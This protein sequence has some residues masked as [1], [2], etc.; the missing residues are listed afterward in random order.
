MVYDKMTVNSSVTMKIPD[1]EQ[2]YGTF[3]SLLVLF[4]IG[5]FTLTPFVSVDCWWHMRMAEHFFENGKPVIFDQ[6]AIQ[7]EQK[8]LATYP[9]LLPGSLFLLFFKLFSIMG[10]NILRILIHIIFIGSLIWGARKSKHIYLILFQILILNFAMSGRIILQPDLFNYLFFFWWIMFL[11][12]YSE[13]PVLRSFIPLIIMELLWINTHPL[14]FFYGLLTGQIYLISSLIKEK[15]GW[16]RLAILSSVW[17]LNPL[18]WRALESLFVNTA[19]SAFRPASLRPLSGSFGSVHTYGYLFLIVL[20]LL[21]LIQGKRKPAKCRTVMMIVLIAPALL[22]IRSFPFLIIYLI[23]IQSRDPGDSSHPVYSRFRPVIAILVIGATLFTIMDRNSL[24]SVKTTSLVNR[25]LGTELKQEY[26]P[27][28]IRVN[29]THP[30]EAI[31]E[32][33]LLNRLAPPGHC[34]TNHMALASC[35]VWFCR[36]KPFTWY[37]HAAVFNRRADDLKDFLIHLPTENHGPVRHFIEKYRIRTVVLTNYSSRYLDLYQH[38]HQSLSLIYIDPY[39]SVFSVPGENRDRFENRLNRFYRTYI[40]G[41]LEKK[42]FSPEDQKR[43]FLYLWFSA[44]MTGN[45]GDPYLKTAMKILPPQTISSFRERAMRIIRS[46][47]TVSA[48]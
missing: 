31:R 11:E 13:K 22:Y 33:H 1:I 3:I 16:W 34:V 17:I 30:I 5:Y 26:A 23:I 45:N 44:E 9:N 43:L 15:K 46:S 48:E 36:D 10:L 14:F 2:R 12:I 19:R 28:G 29:E 6:F 8:I 20:F 18:G 7:T 27:P 47:P 35:A 39:I 32:V 42:R 25:T 37:G 38:F 40:P 41:E 4:A 24:I 21:W